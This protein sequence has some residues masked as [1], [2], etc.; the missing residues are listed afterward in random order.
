M[1]NASEE[2]REI[3]SKGK[4]T[5]SIV[6]GFF[7][8]SSLFL[9]MPE[10]AAVG[11]APASVP[12]VSTTWFESESCIFVA[13]HASPKQALINSTLP[14]SFRS[15]KCSVHRADGPIFIKIPSSLSCLSSADHQTSLRSYLQLL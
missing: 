4:N 2:D 5:F 14:L 8:S 15:L 13:D 9:L 7:F 11:N 1:S 6:W 3:V 10:T 12:L